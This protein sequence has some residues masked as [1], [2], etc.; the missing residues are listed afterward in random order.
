MVGLDQ[1]LLRESPVQVRGGGAPAGGAATR[2]RG[3]SAGTAGRV[4]PGE[5]HSAGAR[6]RARRRTRL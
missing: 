5:R 3:P 1:A 6:G 4:P 2:R